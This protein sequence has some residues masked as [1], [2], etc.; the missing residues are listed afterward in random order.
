MSPMPKPVSLSDE[1][2][3]A[4]MRTCAP[5]QPSERSEL[6][7]RLADRLRAVPE[8]G[9]GQLFRL[10]RDLV[11]QTW[12]PPEVPRETGRDRRHVGSPLE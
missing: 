5:L 9:D 2:L 10:L 4:V 6:L 1:Q 3:A 8:V 7:T 12:R 11:H